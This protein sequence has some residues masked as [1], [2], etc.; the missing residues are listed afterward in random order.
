MRIMAL[1]LP[2]LGAVA[3]SSAVPGNAM[4]K[5]PFLQ[6]PRQRGD[7]RIFLV[8]GARAAKYGLARRHREAHGHVGHCGND[9]AMGLIC[10]VRTVAGAC[11]AG[12]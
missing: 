10:Q 6:A 11:L 9:L 3:L 8:L 5:M 2:V 4:K 7:G 12:A 1:A